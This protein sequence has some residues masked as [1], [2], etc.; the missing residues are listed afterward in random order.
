MLALSSLW[1]RFGAESWD[2]ISKLKGEGLVSLLSYDI[3]LKVTPPP[4]FLLGVMIKPFFI[5]A[6]AASGDRCHFSRS[7]EPVP[8]IR[9]SPFWQRRLFCALH[10]LFC[11]PAVYKRAPQIT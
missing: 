7:R 8:K 1:Q 10:V 11:A 2:E 9:P 3:L 6:V 4:C 5:C